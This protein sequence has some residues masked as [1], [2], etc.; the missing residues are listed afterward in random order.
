MIDCYR[1]IFIRKL[2]GSQKS[3]FGFWSKCVNV[4]ARYID[5]RSGRRLQITLHGFVIMY[6]I[7]V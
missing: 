5:H 2:Q 4:V 1:H 3:L 6:N 7:I